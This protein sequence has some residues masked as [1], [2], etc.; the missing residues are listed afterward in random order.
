MTATRRRCGRA[1]VLC[2]EF[3]SFCLGHDVSLGCGSELAATTTSPEWRI[4]MGQEAL[5][6][7]IRKHTN[8]LFGREVERRCYVAAQHPASP[9]AH[10][11]SARKL[12]PLVYKSKSGGPPHG[13]GWQLLNNGK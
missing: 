5:R 13:L 6:L 11:A 1:R 3:G 9:S 8:A 4:A 7:I 12:S 10:R 2:L